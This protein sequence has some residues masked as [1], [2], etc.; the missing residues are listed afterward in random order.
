MTMVSVIARHEAISRPPLFKEGV[1]GGHISFVIL[2]E[3]EGSRFFDSS[4]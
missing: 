1:G 3:C 4:E 2:N